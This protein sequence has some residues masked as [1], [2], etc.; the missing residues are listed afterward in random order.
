VVGH[1]DL[2]ERARGRARGVVWSEAGSGAR[3]CL[4]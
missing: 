3:C 2:L 1:A 4:E